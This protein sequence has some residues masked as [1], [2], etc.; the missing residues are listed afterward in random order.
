[1]ILEKQE[2]EN[3]LADLK[4]K[5]KKITEATHA[6]NLKEVIEKSKQPVRT[7]VT[8]DER[9]GRDEAILRTIEKIRKAAEEDEKLKTD[10]KK[11]PFTEEE[12]VTTS[13]GVRE[14][15]WKSIK[16]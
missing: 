8:E 3:T 1:M 13:C 11:E 16:S 5:T 2:Q 14:F 4:K 12:V 10:V 15:I 7:E 6:G 9:I